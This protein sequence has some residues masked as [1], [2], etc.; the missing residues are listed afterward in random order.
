MKMPL[1]IDKVLAGDYW[2]DAGALMGVLP[3]AIWNS[4]LLCDSK[5]RLRMSLNLLLIRDQERIIL[6]DTGLGNRLTDKQLKIYNPSEFLLPMSLGQMG[7]RDIDVT[8]VI[9]THL[10]FDHAG[11][12]ISVFGDEDKL[13]FPEAN[14][15]IQSS[16]WDM[17]KNP[18][19]LNRAAYNFEQQ[20][21]L[22]EALGKLKLING[23]L[24]I[25]PGIKL[26][27]VG[28]HTVGSQI[29]EIQTESALYIYAGDIIP[30]TMHIFPPVTSAYDVSRADTFKA[31][32]Y[33]F[34]RL[35]DTKGFL[36]LDHDND[37]WQ[38]PAVEL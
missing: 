5:Q 11:G 20:L 30:T 1:T 37:K 16:E 32:E 26:K 25:Y 21:S 4:K 15:W 17:A 6:V 33:I 14:Y 28:G 23:D 18:D 34:Q 19:A 13:T 24:E 2:S 12:I 38:I 31:K 27:K 9:M 10:H 29:V 36:L 7:I 22:L 8:D 35:K 3:W